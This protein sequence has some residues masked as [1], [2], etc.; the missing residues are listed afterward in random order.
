VSEIVVVIGAGSIEQAIA[1]RVSAGKHVLLADLHDENT[2][3]AAEHPRRVGTVGALLMGHEGAFITG[4]DFL[5]GGGVT[6]SVPYV[7]SGCFPT[8]SPGAR[9]FTSWWRRGHDRSGDD[10]AGPAEPDHLPECVVVK[11]QARRH[12]DDL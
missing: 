3:A 2:A 6:A 1:R 10:Q 4:S 9:S 11:R 5:M 7:G 8:M 12:F